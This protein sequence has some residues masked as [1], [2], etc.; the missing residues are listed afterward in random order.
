MKK[1][2]REPSQGFKA[3][4]EGLTPNIKI[5]EEPHSLLE[6]ADGDRLQRMLHDL[7]EA[8]F[9]A[10]ELNSFNKFLRDLPA[11][12]EVLEAERNATM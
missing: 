2:Q 3:T 5:V 9:V 7:F 11:I 4:V 10:S 6:A 1:T 8:R 12:A